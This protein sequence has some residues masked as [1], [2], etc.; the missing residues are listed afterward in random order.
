LFRSAGSKEIDIVHEL[1]VAEARLGRFDQRLAQEPYSAAVRK[2]LN[3]IRRKGRR[4]DED[5]AA[6]AKAAESLIEL[7]DKVEQGQVKAANDLNA[8]FIESY[9]VDIDHR[10]VHLK[11]EEVAHLVDKPAQHLERAIE[12][13]NNKDNQ[14]AATEIRKA[15]AFFNLDEARAS[16]APRDALNKTMANLAA[17]AMQLEDKQP[18]KVSELETAFGQAHQALANYHHSRAAETTDQV[19]AGY[20]LQAAAHHLER[21]LLRTGHSIEGEQATFINALN[22]IANDMTA[23]KNLNAKQVSQTLERLGQE[24]EDLGQEIGT[25]MHVPDN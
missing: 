12:V 1:L 18:L 19:E 21:A 11:S 23:G 4:S 6:R 15:L 10:L 25:T 8:A 3:H 24:L 17:L 2:N 14:L 9:R 5:I 20:E 22:T 16:G 13:F 7:A